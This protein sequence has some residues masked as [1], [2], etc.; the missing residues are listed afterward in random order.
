M[1]IISVSERLLLLWCYYIVQYQD[2]FFNPVKSNLKGICTMAAII[3]LKI[4]LGFFLTAIHFSISPVGIGFLFTTK[5]LIIALWNNIWWN[6]EEKNLNHCLT[7]SV[8]KVAKKNL[9]NLHKAAS[10]SPSH[11]IEIFFQGHGI[12]LLCADNV[13]YDVGW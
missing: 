13:N 1:F 5:T 11:C 8:K 9:G 12:I 7:K 6:V 10:M 4:E 2:L 3:N